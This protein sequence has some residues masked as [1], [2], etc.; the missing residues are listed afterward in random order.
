MCIP[1]RSNSAICP[2]EKLSVDHSRVEF[3]QRCREDE[4]HSSGCDDLLLVQGILHLG[5]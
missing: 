1:N 2:R 3:A 4:H 5:S